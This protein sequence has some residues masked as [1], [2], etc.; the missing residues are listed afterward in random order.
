MAS[1]TPEALAADLRA[2]LRDIP[3]F[4]QPGIVFKDITPAL[5]DP[6]LLARVV[7]GLADPAAGADLIVGIESRGFLFGTPVALALG[8][9]FAP[10]RKPG[11]LPYHTVEVAYDLEY[12]SA[13]LQ[14]HVDA[15]GPDL[16]RPPRVVIVDDVLATGGTA[17]AAAALVA[18][19]GG[20]VH[21]CVFP[22]EL[23]FLGGRARL[24]GTVHSLTRF[25]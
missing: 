3:D 11:K 12:G 24:G 7:A 16:G 19:L 14:A 1:S 23:G 13:R 9:P 21:A 20:V 18:Q 8:V 6:A 2:A 17:A 5:H 15:L 10:F 4:P 25:D 22:I